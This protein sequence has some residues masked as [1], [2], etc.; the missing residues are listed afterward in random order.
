MGAALLVVVL[1]PS[2]AL[3]CA[4]PP[5]VVYHQGGIAY[6]ALQ[7]AHVMGARACVLTGYLWKRIHPPCQPVG[8]RHR[9][10]TRSPNY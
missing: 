9:R 3:R 6:L 10:P 5:V 1:L 8:I 2:Q 4:K 7:A